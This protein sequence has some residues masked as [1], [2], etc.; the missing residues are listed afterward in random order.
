MCP[1]LTLPGTLAASHYGCCCPEECSSLLQWVAAA[2]GHTARKRQSWDSGTCLAPKLK[3]HSDARECKWWLAGETQH[4]GAVSLALVLNPLLAWVKHFYFKVP[5][6][7]MHTYLITC[8]SPFTKQELQGSFYAQ[9]PS[10]KSLKELVLAMRAHA[11]ELW[12]EAKVHR[13]GQ[14]GSGPR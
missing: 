10:F 13:S 12:L 14:P 11:E 2:P 7:P 8:M 1:T 4:T 3:P 6:T 9:Q 5:A